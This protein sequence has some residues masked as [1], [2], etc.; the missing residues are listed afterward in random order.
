MQVTSKNKSEI[1]EQALNNLVKSHNQ[2]TATSKHKAQ[3]NRAILADRSALGV[4]FS[5]EIKEICYPII[6]ERSQ[7]SKIWDIDGNEYIDILMGLGVNLLGHNPPFIKEA[8][9]Q[10]LEKGIQVGS[11]TILAAEVAQLVKDLTGMERVTLSNTGTEAI[12]AAIRI[13]RAATKRKKIALFTNSYH[14]HSDQTL[15]RATLAEYAKKAIN[16]KISEKIG[17]KSWLSQLMRPLQNQLQNNLNPKAVPAALGIPPSQAKDVLVLE[18]GNDKS[19]DIIKANRKQ[20]A[21]VLVEPVQSRCPQVQPEAFIKE[22]RQVTQEGGIALIFDEMV[23]GFRIHQGGAQ[24]WFGIDADI[25]T[26]SKIAG[27]GLPLSII[28]GKSTYLNRIDGGIW[29]FGDASSPSVET[30]FFAGTYC[31]H[32]LS[33]AAAKATLTHLKTEGATLQETLNQKTAKMVDCLNSDL[34]SQGLMLKF[35]CFGSFFAL[36]LSQSVISPL[37]LTLLSYY[38]LSR[39]I[40]LRQGDRGGFLSTS[41]TDNDINLIIQAFKDSINDLQAGGFLE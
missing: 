6:I 36:D 7:G 4:K 27:G 8:I 35:T 33:L 13:A 16:R 31:K 41:H 28:A 26:Y 38:L 30:T 12:M 10:Q 24:A 11:Q 18:Y 20:L 29:N 2:K 14:G 37:A 5:P 1:Q 40:H 39:G 22:L 32:P 34:A 9:A 15:V 19:L 21:A 3:Q 25:V 23:T 17:D